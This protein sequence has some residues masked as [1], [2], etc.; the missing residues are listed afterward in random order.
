MHTEDGYVVAPRRG[1]GRGL[2]KGQKR[3]VWT[4]LS[5][6][7]DGLRADGV[8]TWL[9]LA[10]EAARLVA[11]RASPPFRHVVVDE[12]QD[13]HPAQWRLLRAAVAVGPDDLFLTGDPHQR[14]YGNH[15]SLRNV[16]VSVAGRSSR[17]RINYR[18][19]A[20]I[21]RW[22]LGL[23]GDIAIAD[24]DDGLDS[25][26]GYRSALHGAEPELAGARSQDQE[27]ED[28]A[29]ALEQWHEEGVGWGDMAVVARTR[30]VAQRLA[31]ELDR[32]GVATAE[33]TARDS[34]TDAVRVG[35]MHGMKGLE[36]RCVA[37]AGAGRSAIPLAQA[38][39][40]ATEDPVRH[41]LDLQQE[42]C[43]L[44]VACTRARE[45]LRV[46]WSGPRSALIP[47]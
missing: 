39:T 20:E 40:P 37:V 8:W 6:F 22:S 13:L 47:G 44:F 35:T 24:L 15:V 43:L 42:R 21:L 31:R 46:S 36:F 3:T 17:L 9:T 12:I 38:V 16:G 19:S 23:L 34:G 26:T 33:L 25:L 41:A 27:A 2:T 29:L 32:H 5:R 28:L 18:T 10:D 1:R 30:W 4:A 11:G 7:V 14:I 45:R